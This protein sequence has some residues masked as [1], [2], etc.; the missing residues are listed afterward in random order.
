MSVF[1]THILR[2]L[3]QPT[4]R[5]SKVVTGDPGAAHVS[6]SYVERQNL[7][8]R[9]GM[10]RFKRMTNDFS[11]KVDNL[12]HAVSLHF[13]YNN[14]YRTH[15]SLKEPTP[16]MADGIAYHQWGINGPAAADWVL[17]TERQSGGRRRGG[18]DP[19]PFHERPSLV[20]CRIED[21][22]LV[23]RQYPAI[24]QHHLAV[25]D[26][27]LDTVANGLVDQPVDDHPVRRQV[28]LA[29]VDDGDAGLLPRFERA[30]LIVP[31]QRLRRVD[32]DHLQ[33]LANR[34]QVPVA[35]EKL[36]DELR[37]ARGLE[38]VEARLRRGS[39]GRDRR[40]HAGLYQLRH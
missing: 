35:L 8:M 1:Q 37:L 24:L 5:S 25:D 13:L 2:L 30:E 15:R 6:T 28:G 22:L 23:D 36:V 12:A 18:S 7:T 31:A 4:P 16:A 11:K 9:M 34:Q 17:T 20:D 27:R 39:V 40:V 14:F 10:R 33:Q 29:Q 38:Q 26:D 3:N 32:R 19:S 21:R